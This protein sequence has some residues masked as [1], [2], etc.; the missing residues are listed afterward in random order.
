MHGNV[1]DMIEF[2]IDDKKLEV[3]EGSM[4]IEAADAAGIYIPRFCYHKKLTI[5]GNCRMCLVEVEKSKKPL[6]ACATPVTAG[7]KVFS[8]SK[9]AL[10]AQRSVM[11]FLLINHP[12]DCPICDQGGECELQDLSLGYG[13]DISRYTE[14]KRSVF[15]EDLGPLIATEMTRCIQCTRCVRFGIEVAGM[16]ELGAVQRGENLEIS[17]YI[18]KTIESELSGNIIDLCPVGA[19]TSKPYR[20]TARPWELKQHPSI[21]PHDCVGSNIFVHT[22]GYEYNDYRQV[23]RVAP[24]ENETINETWISDRDRFSYQAV[25]S[26]DRILTPKIRLD[27]EWVN[28]DWTTAI[29]TIIEKWHSIIKSHGSDQIGAIASPNSTVEEFYLLQKLIRALGSNNVDHRIKQLDFSQ[30]ENFPSHPLLGI[31]F[32]ELEKKDVIFLVGS[33]I[34]KEQP[35]ACH[36]VRKASLR[37]AKVFCL[38]PID[39]DFNFT[40]SENLIVPML[41]IPRTLAGI[42]KRLSLEDSNLEAYLKNIKPTK[43]EIGFAE[44]L[45]QGNNGVLILGSQ[46]IC[47]PEATLIRAL[48]ERIA[49]KCGMVLGTLTDG[50]NAAGA[51]LTGMIPHRGFGGAHI[52]KAGLNVSD[53]LS[54]RL[55]SYVLLNV[56]PGFDFARS[57]ES[58]ESLMSSEFVITMTPFIN[59]VQEQY[60]HVILPVSPF[61]ETSGT[62]INAADCWQSFEAVTRPLGESK[63]AWK[64]LRVLGNRLDS[65]GFNY[66]SSPQIITE[67]K[68]AI[69]NFPLHENRTLELVDRK[70]PEQEGL[71]RL[72]E[73]PMYQ[74][75]SFIRRAIALQA[76]S[77]EIEKVVIRI[78]SNIAKKYDIESGEVIS[79]TQDGISLQLPVLID[80]SIAGDYV[81]VPAGVAETVGFG[82]G[83]APIKLQR[84]HS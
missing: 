15:D 2:E 25:Q 23:M 83:M 21:A 18:N 43:Q 12:L 11:E 13:D 61:F 1:R 39:Y 27:S 34:R 64:V 22:R 31:P 26:I 16:P 53:M 65:E 35:L 73:W 81:V 80:N 72:I 19:L 74:T 59:D 62:F 51:W 36:R 69:A 20:F 60:S 79:I 33:N 48:A 17:T 45:K 7:M 82:E 52:D 76:W 30:Q 32:A 6:P 40:I 75:D 71:L 70:A 49:N 42:A 37:G 14:G 24:R 44:N 29:N 8:K 58:I 56:E 9:A 47:H 57:M 28:V 41:E 54:N 77:Q 68:H 66:T 84:G 67:L 63:P 10:E 4:I 50:A 55:K 3:A 5:A 38:N 46:A 78:N